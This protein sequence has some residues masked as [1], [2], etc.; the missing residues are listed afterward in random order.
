MP[1]AVRCHLKSSLIHAD[2]FVFITAQWCNVHFML[3]PQYSPCSGV[4]YVWQME[5]CLEQVAFSIKKKR[6]TTQKIW[7]ETGR[8]ITFWCEMGGREGEWPLLV[9]LFCFSKLSF[10]WTEK[11]LQEKALPCPGNKLF[12]RTQRL[13]VV[14]TF[15]PTPSFLFLLSLPSYLFALG[16]H[17]PL[18]LSSL[19]FQPSQSSSTS[20][21][22]PALPSQINSSHWKADAFYPV[23]CSA[24]AFSR[25]QWRTLLITHHPMNVFLSLITLAELHV[26][27]FRLPL[28]RIFSVSN[29]TRPRQY[30][31]TSKGN[32][33]DA[34][35][36]FGQPTYK[37]ALG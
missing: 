32:R 6:Q 25:I 20:S 29:I 13:R 30:C 28:Y 18:V 12:A 7:K 9:F 24:G 14:P 17:L 2:V 35:L 19:A 27:Q 3:T 22:H 4:P 1:T 11:R 26:V 5:I 8:E 10:I 33:C 36:G 23:R 15:S 16:L 31:K 21:P 37:A 34:H